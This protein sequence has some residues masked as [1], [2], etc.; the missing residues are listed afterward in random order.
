MSTLLNLFK[1][2]FQWLNSYLVSPT[3]Q[4]W[5]T[6]V[7]RPS[8]TRFVTF[9]YGIPAL[10]LAFG[11]EVDKWANDTTVSSYMAQVGVPN[12]VPATMAG[13]ALVY[14]IAHGRD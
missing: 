4:W 12:W 6:N 1:T 8:W 9:L 7:W 14:Y 3:H 5:V 13:V 10:L 2:P 11:Q